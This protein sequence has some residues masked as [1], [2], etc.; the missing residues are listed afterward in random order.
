MAA[1]SKALVLTQKSLFDT[2]QPQR[3]ALLA[4]MLPLALAGPAGDLG[5]L[6]R[7]VSLVLCCRLCLI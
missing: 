4:F 5:L 3:A 7:F 1:I 2:M 6:R